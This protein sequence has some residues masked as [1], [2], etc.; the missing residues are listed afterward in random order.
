[1]WRNQLDPMVRQFSI[2]F[3]AVVGPI[4][5]QKSGI[6]SEKPFFESV[7]YKGDFV[8]RSRRNVN[9]ERKTSAVCQRHELCT[10]APLGFSD[11]EA[12]FFAI[13][14]VASM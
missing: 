11:P 10:L 13:I 3:V 6:R 5:D 7:A 9:G 8:R 12:P 4:T 2:K 14:K 1:M